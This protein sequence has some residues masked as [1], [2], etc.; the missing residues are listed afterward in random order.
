MF[1]IK[2]SLTKVEPAIPNCE[3]V[4]NKASVAIGVAAYKK[5]IK[6]QK[7]KQKISDWIIDASD[8]L[9][10]TLF[11]ASRTIVPFLNV[12]GELLFIF[13]LIYNLSTISKI[14]GECNCVGSIL[15]ILLFKSQKMVSPK[16][17]L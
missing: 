14:N 2:T 13:S 17:N 16:S 4:I 8:N 9:W 12:C 15:S 5:K 7:K 10:R 11:L 6:K 1:L 3:A